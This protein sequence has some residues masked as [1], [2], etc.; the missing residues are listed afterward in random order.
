MGNSMTA[1][2][3]ESPA[4]LT[5]FTFLAAEVNIS[6]IGD[7]FTVYTKTPESMTQVQ[8]ALNTVYISHFFSWRF[9]SVHRADHQ[10]DKYHFDTFDRDAEHFHIQFDQPLNA[11]NLSIIL[12]SFVQHHVLSVQ[13]KGELLSTYLAAPRLSQKEV[14]TSFAA[15]HFNQLKESLKQYQTEFPNQSELQAHITAVLHDF[16]AIILAGDNLVEAQKYLSQIKP[17][18]DDPTAEN[19]AKL[20]K[21]GHQAST[22]SSLLWK[23]LGITLTLL[24]TAMMVAVV[25]LYMSPGIAAITTGYAGLCFFNLGIHY[26]RQP[27]LRQDKLSS[28][29]IALSQNIPRH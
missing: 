26:I 10:H 4:T 13:E 21:L 12:D 17:L 8:N 22:V 11:D 1:N 16:E 15:M 25:G 5:A 14:D 3:L 19:M 2:A 27:A 24:G 28:D 20:K 23:A 7:G 18:I 9:N 29:L 6:I